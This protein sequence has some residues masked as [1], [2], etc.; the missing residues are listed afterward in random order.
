MLLAVKD[1]VLI[2]LAFIYYRNYFLKK[3]ITAG[4]KEYLGTVAMPCYKSTG[5]L[6]GFVFMEFETSSKSSGGGSWNLQADPAEEKQLCR[7]QKLPNQ[8]S[9]KRLRKTLT[10]RL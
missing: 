1:L 4:L 8:K 2:I 10:K 6:K 9:R 7:G 5:D 3:F